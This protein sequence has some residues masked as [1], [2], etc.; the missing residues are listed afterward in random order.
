VSA[1]FTYAFHAREVRFEVDRG[2]GFATVF[3]ETFSFHVERHD[4][5]ELYLQLEDLWTRPRLISPEAARRDAE[6]VVRRF[7]SGL[8]PYLERLLDRLEQAQQLSPGTLA[9]VH[10]D[11][12]A[13]ALVM[14]RFVAD[15]KLDESEPQRLA[16]FHL[17]KLLWRCLMGLV[18][19]RVR[20]DALDRYRGG[21]LPR[22]AAGE[23]LSEAT[24]LM[25]LAGPDEEL[26]ERQV[27]LLA[28]RAYHGWL[29]EVCL[30]E[31]NTSFDSESSP[32][33]DRETEVKRAC[34]APGA[35]RL[36]RGRDLSP[37][38][39]RLRSKDCTRLLEKV[40]LYFLRQYDVACSSL[41]IQHMAFLGKGLDVPDRILTRHSAT[42]YA[43]ALTLLS[44]PFLGAA[45]AY[46]RAPLI[47]DLLASAEV[48]LM[49]AGVLWYLT[50]QFAWR[51]DLTLFFAGVP[52]IGAG[53]IVGYL[54][55]FL[56]DEVW[57]LS[58]KA[59]APLAAVAVLLALTTLLYLYV[60]V[61]RRLG[62][63]AAAFNRA[64]AIFL[65]GLL[66]A[67]VFGLIATGLIGP[68][69]TERVW[70]EGRASELSFL[71]LR[72]QIPPFVGELPRVLG[73]SPIF[74][75]PTTVFLMTFLS[76]FIGTFL[77][78]LWEDLPITEP[79]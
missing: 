70:N 53:I 11:L 21:G 45:F 60:E 61:Q 47:W 22:L 30:D 57:S 73:V 3:P 31:S 75:F 24:L 48:L 37:F 44:L 64:R 14:L 34:A 62:E 6:A 79:L 20:P 38:L 68:F 2:E 32:F 29:E 28:E 74:A 4:P 56:I 33:S 51:K 15:K 43:I 25:A 40:K 54:P 19:A 72:D 39:R 10:E 49:T 16:G 67:F 76:I 41:V 66:E 12:A 36:L 69:M 78:L 58:L 1:R 9:R 27:L 42:N 8:P 55:V 18:S 26:A 59:F 71:V 35:A 5:A 50:V 7:V 46:Q 13:L 63:S 65:L 17:R 52:R 77:Q 23:D